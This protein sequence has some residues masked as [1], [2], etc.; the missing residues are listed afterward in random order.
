LT[1]DITIN[2]A[3]RPRDGSE[4][5]EKL[6]KTCSANKKTGSVAHPI[7]TRQGEDPLRQTLEV[8]GSQETSS[9]QPQP[10]R[11]IDET[12]LRFFFKWGLEQNSEEVIDECINFIQNTLKIKC[13]K[14]QS[15]MPRFCVEST[16]TMPEIKKLFSLVESIIEVSG[17][18]SFGVSLSMTED[19]WETLKEFI[20][21]HHAYVTGL[22][23][24]DENFLDW[25][26]RNCSILAMLEKTTNVLGIKIW[27]TTLN[28]G[29]EIFQKLNQLKKLKG[30]EI[31]SK[32]L[33]VAPNLSQLNQLTDLL[34]RNCPNL[35]EPPHMGELNKLE[36]VVFSNCPNLK[37]VPDLSKQRSLKRL[38]FH[39]CPMMEGSFDSEALALLECL[40][41]SG[42]GR[43]Q[44]PNVENLIHLKELYLTSCEG[45]TGYPDISK[46][47]KLER[48]L[49][50][51][52]DRV[53]DGKEEVLKNEIDDQKMK[54]LLQAIDINPQLLPQLINQLKVINT[55][56]LEKKLAER[57]IYIYMKFFRC[58]KNVNIE[59]N[60]SVLEELSNKDLSHKI[61][62]ENLIEFLVVNAI[63]TKRGSKTLSQKAIKLLEKIT[64]LQFFKSPNLLTIL[65]PEYTTGE[66]IRNFSSILPRIVKVLGEKKV[67]VNMVM[68]DNNLSES[69]DLIN[70]N[71]SVVKQMCFYENVFDENIATV[72]ALL[73]KTE[74]LLGLTIS[75]KT[76]NYDHAIFQKINQLKCLQNLRFKNC[77]GMTNPPD[78]SQIK[79]LKHLAFIDCISLTE[80]PEVSELTEL[81]ELIIAGSPR[82]KNISVIEN[83]QSLESLNLSGCTG[84]RSYPDISRLTKLKELYV[85]DI[86]PMIGMDSA[87]DEKAINEM[88]V[89]LCHQAFYIN[90]EI[91]Y[92]LINSLKIDYVDLMKE[93]LL[94][95]IA[96]YIIFGLNKKDITPVITSL[97]YIKRI[98]NIEFFNIEIMPSGKLIFGI[99][100]MNDSESIRKL[101]PILAYI[102]KS[103]EP[104]K[105][106]IKLKLTADNFQATREFIDENGKYICSINI[107]NGHVFD[108]NKSVLKSIFKQTTNLNALLISSNKKIIS[109]RVFA[110]IRQLKALTHLNFY[111]CPHMESPPD[112]GELR[113]LKYL[114]FQNC[115]AMKAP[116]DLSNLKE[117]IE[118]KF[119]QLRAMRT[120]PKVDHLQKLQTLDLS[121]CTSL[122]H[123]PNIEGLKALKTIKVPDIGIMQLSAHND[124]GTM[125]ELIEKNE[126]LQR[127][128]SE[129]L[130]QALDISPALFINL[131]SQLS[132]NDEN[133]L[134]FQKQLLDYNLQFFLQNI[135]KFKS[136]DAS[137]CMKAIEMIASSSPEEDVSKVLYLLISTIQLSD[138]MW[139]LCEATLREQLA[140]IG[141]IKNYCS[142]YA[143]DWNNKDSLILYVLDK[144]IQSE[145][146]L[147]LQ[148]YYTKFSHDI[149]PFALEFL[150]N[151]EHVKAFFIEND[152]EILFNEILYKFL[153]RIYPSGNK[154][155]YKFYPIKIS[156]QSSFASNS[157]VLSIACNIEDP[158]E[159]TSDILSI[160][161]ASILFE[162]MPQNIYTQFYGN[163]G[164]DGAGLSRSLVSG[165]MKGI[166]ANRTNVRLTEFHGSRHLKLPYLSF[167]NLNFQDLEDQ[168]KIQGLNDIGTFLGLLIQTENNYPIGEVFH[169][170]FFRILL[171]FSLEDLNKPT[172][173][174]ANEIAGL[175]K[176]TLLA[177]CRNLW[178]ISHLKK[179][180][181]LG[182]IISVEEYSD[183]DQKGIQKINKFLQPYEV[184][185]GHNF[186]SIKNQIWAEVNH[187]LNIRLVHKIAK[188]QNFEDLTKMDKD[189]FIDLCH[190]L[191]IDFQEGDQATESSSDDQQNLVSDDMPENGFAVAKNLLIAEIL[192]PHL[193]IL[194]GMHAVARGLVRTFPLKVKRAINENTTV[195]QISNLQD[196]KKLGKRELNLWIQGTLT[197]SG[198]KEAIMINSRLSGDSDGTNSLDEAAN[199][200]KEWLF[201]WIDAPSTTMANVRAFV[202]T[203]TGSTALPISKSITLKISKNK[204]QLC[205]QTC[206]KKLIVP[207]KTTHEG[208]MLWLKDCLPAPEIFNL[209]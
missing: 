79:T 55:G 27:S 56:S 108:S 206:Y 73:D 118:L 120:P 96:N 201:E 177:K 156:K 13:I 35:E 88:K 70:N 195:T 124:F 78:L 1:D 112:L 193:E 146:K 180:R 110:K 134:T 122:T 185:N 173:E 199:N 166:A 119:S 151:L 19:N 109:P 149:G 174:F 80:A 187:A 17:S 20:D 197:K 23:F 161:A 21:K 184:I 10:G 15:G 111:N 6:K 144:C 46:L 71:A 34:F 3:K 183:L 30:L 12:N 142:K 131:L 16:S 157:Q 148:K 106:G 103:F 143:L 172:F 114:F 65:I 25:H 94:P 29:D 186:S 202:K 90:P 62:E 51:C 179:V 42:S 117:L 152:N 68:K 2:N 89:E 41:L 141:E 200:I 147:I 162:E 95:I 9:V 190:N 45:M 43:V 113:Q 97:D 182:N 159:R 196:L 138:E 53:E 92:R 160:A 207:M 61:H 203:V 36:T 164:I 57:D 26:E 47:T 130:Q 136:L 60:L 28:G 33:I 158:E 81:V 37:S 4:E 84:M 153:R 52:I 5:S 14:N 44:V 107:E 121:G 126:K 50:P 76:I 145:K 135:N 127:N 188:A 105:V 167:K 176:K 208:F 191:C 169:E 150:G 72:E 39:N 154:E 54:L 192:R 209:N 75:S 181:K 63:Q 67:Q 98:T 133:T 7:L 129:L 22:K 11:P 87:S 205:A 102:L 175:P 74:T 93:K 59:T 139:N 137:T 140:Q 115:T 40:Q 69:V 189:L 49:L 100:N 8:L 18:S 125:E 165:L 168:G 85:P 64:K 32:A 31:S 116:P 170:Y 163:A 82:I 77:L 123:Y 83:L 194:L 91:S 38:S 48:L 128:K 24:E 99:K 204:D 66:H 86:K 171:G 198:L 132:L 104:D 178:D 58:F 101:T 155:N